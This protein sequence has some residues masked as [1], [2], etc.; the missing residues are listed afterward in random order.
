MRDIPDPRRQGTMTF[1]EALNGFMLDQQL[2]FATLLDQDLIRDVFAKHGALFGGVFHTAI[3]L[4]AFLSQVL[5]DGK[6][7][8]CQSAVARISAF[9]A[10]AGRYIPFP[11][12]GDY[13][14]A[15]AKLK[16]IALQA[17]SQEVALRAQSQADPKWKWRGLRTFLVDGFT[18]QMPDTV[19]N[20]EAYPQ[21]TAQKPGI[22]FP[23]ARAVAMVCLATGVVVSAAI[24]R[25]KGKQTGELALFKQLFGHLKPGDVV[26]ADRHYC[27]YWMICALLKMG[28]HVCFRKHQKRHTDFRKGK[29]LGAKDHI[30]VWPR[31]V[32]PKWMS[33]TDYDE[34]P[35]ELRLREIGYVIEE[36]GRKQQPF[37]IVTTMLGET[38]SDNASK[39]EIAS[40]YGFRW[41]VEL[42]IRSI[43]SN[44]NLGFMRCK[45]P[46]MIHREFWVTI[47]AYNLIRSTVA[48]AASLHDRLPRQISFTAACQFVLTTWNQCIASMSQHERL[49]YCEQL[50]RSVAHCQVAHRPDRFEP[51]VVKRRRDQ[52]QLMT[53]PRHELR[54]RLAGGDNA[55]E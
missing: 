6:E 31:S 32:R 33:K 11:N 4:W 10:Q 43:K 39:D 38:D 12:T 8:S 55:F 16:E 45:S 46:E 18:F 30:V 29:R 23:I 26:V 49:S 9:L 20:Q 19:K 44:M 24:G 36:P 5:R 2:A 53:Q 17:L 35:K 37:V 21:H 47:L 48:L 14:K 15:R 1:R 22:G 28:V 50:L 51:R 27:S 42:D 52:Y 41:N 25:Y 7:A 13:C 40:L 54:K 34:L 3:V